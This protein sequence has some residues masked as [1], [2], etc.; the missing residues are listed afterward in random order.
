MVAVGLENEKQGGNMKKIYSLAGSTLVRD[1]QRERFVSG[2]P[3]QFAIFNSILFAK[4]NYMAVSSPSDSYTVMGKICKIIGLILELDACLRNY[5][6]NTATT[7]NSLH[8]YLII[9][10]YQSKLLERKCDQFLWSL[11]C[12]N[13]IHCRRYESTSW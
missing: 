8:Y 2:L 1:E 13:I 3:P 7:Q 10:V 4:E 12:Q 5:V 11:S 6:R 9:L